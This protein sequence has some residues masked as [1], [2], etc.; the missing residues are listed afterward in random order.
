LYAGTVNVSDTRKKGRSGRRRLL[1][2][3]RVAP[4]EAHRL[5]RD[6]RR[7]RGPLEE[8]LQRERV[9]LC[10][11][12]LVSRGGGRRRKDVHGYLPFGRV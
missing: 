2:G 10:I 9:R 5:P 3:V 12:I 6:A 4:D 11:F 7:G 8:R 1:D